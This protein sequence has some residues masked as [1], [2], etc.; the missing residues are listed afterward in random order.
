MSSPPS[1]STRTLWA[2]HCPQ[3]TPWVSKLKTEKSPTPKFTP[4]LSAA[5]PPNKPQ[6][7]RG[8]TQPQAALH[9]PPHQRL[10]AENMLPECVVHISLLRVTSFRNHRWPGHSISSTW[11]TNSDNSTTA[12]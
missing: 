3:K 9:C 1:P 8:F 10:Q 11:E 6:L 12:A 5:K 7:L 2:L 4:D